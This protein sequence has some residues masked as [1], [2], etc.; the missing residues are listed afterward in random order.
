MG[1]GGEVFVCL[2][3]AG[4]EWIEIR[5]SNDARFFGRELTNGNVENMPFQI[6]RFQI[7]LAFVVNK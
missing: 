5:K 7:E 3:F 1:G 2:V 4:M 6:R